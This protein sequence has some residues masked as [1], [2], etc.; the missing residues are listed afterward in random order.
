MS[1]MFIQG[2]CEGVFDD[3]VPNVPVGKEGKFHVAYLTPSRVEQLQSAGMKVTH[4]RP[5]ETKNT[6]LFLFFKDN[7]NTENCRNMV[8]SVLESL[9]NAGALNKFSEVNVQSNLNRSETGTKV[10]VNFNRRDHT[11][12]Q[13][14][15]CRQMLSRNYDGQY[16]ECGFVHQVKENPKLKR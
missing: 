16:V 10:Y 12:F 7:N 15:C 14:M 13:I 3:S 2:N 9:S 8:R 11:S 5:K 6:S 4:F 1:Y